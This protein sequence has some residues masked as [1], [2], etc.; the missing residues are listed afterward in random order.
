MNS[1]VFFLLYFVLC[2]GVAYIGRNR[3][4]GYWGHL[5]ASIIFSPLMG[6]L[7]VFAANPNENQDA[8]GKD[9]PYEVDR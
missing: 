4:W 2:V 1:Y 5:W 9:E 3:K 7:F 8:K 6:L